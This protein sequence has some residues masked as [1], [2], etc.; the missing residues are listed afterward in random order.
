MRIFWFLF[1][2]LPLSA[3]ALYNGNP[4][5]PAMPES[6][7]F[8]SEDFWFGVKTGYEVDY[9]FYRQ[10]H[11][12]GKGLHG[13]RKRGKDFT[14]LSNFGVLTFNFNDRVEIFTTLGTM[15]AHFSQRP[16]EDKTVSYHTDSNFAWGV[17]GRALLAYWGELQAT[18]N[19]AYVQSDLNL[20]SL[21]VNGHSYS[22]RDAEANFIEWQV[23]AGISYRVDWFIPYFGVDFSDFRSR[24]EHLRSISFI[25]PKKHVTF[26]ESHPIGL[27]LGFGV[28]A[29]KGFALNIEGRIINEYAVSA[30]ADIKY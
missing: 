15:S 11:L 22:T 2:F 20:S 23:G 25:F 13:L 6:G 3:F 10:L 5:L 8:I 29:D 19:A 7:L 4:A 26:K 17:G 24:F 21:K 18:V 30:S 16:L 12:K 28:S 1:L 9:V 14:S 27:F